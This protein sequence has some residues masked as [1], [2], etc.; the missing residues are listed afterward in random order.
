MSPFGRPLLL[1]VFVGA[2]LLSMACSPSDPQNTLAAQGIVAKK[3]QDLFWVVAAWAAG[4]F[5]VVE[6]LLLFTLWRFRHRPGQGEPHQTHGN[7]RLEIA[8]TIAPALVLI[9]VAVPTV[10]LLWELAEPPRVA[11]DVRVT[12][13]QWWWEFEYPGHGVVT[14]NELHIPVGETVQFHL[15]SADVIHSFWVPK[16]AGKMDVIPGKTNTFWIRADSPGTY[17]AQC[18]ELC[19]V[20]HANMKFRVIAQ[21]RDQFEQW[22]RAQRTPARQP[23]PGTPEAAGLEV[24]RTN[25]IACHTVDGV[26]GAV[27]KVGPNLTHFGS[28]QTL[29]AGVVENNLQNLE[30][31]I[32]DT[33]SLKPGVEMA[34]TPMPRFNQTLTPE[35][36]QAVARFVAGLR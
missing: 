2:L 26:P 31:W 22:V 34:R 33:S 9:T 23:D 16:L 20:Q 21:P 12:G 17:F 15:T 36:I 24:F 14:A 13:H 35:Q 28:R 10:S 6:A 19:G 5:V 18:A 27:G 11:M 1:L 8:W 7:T 30:T 4:V 29:A 3:Q 25:C 32:A